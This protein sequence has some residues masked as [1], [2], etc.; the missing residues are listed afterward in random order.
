MIIKRRWKKIKQ[1]DLENGKE[2]I[3]CDHEI[4]CF[5]GININDPFLFVSK[6]EEVETFHSHGANAKTVVNIMTELE[7][8]FDD[9]HKDIYHISSNRDPYQPNVIEAIHID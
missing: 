6:Y 5:C 2:P 7:K 9:S 3:A 8:Y 1:L 4:K